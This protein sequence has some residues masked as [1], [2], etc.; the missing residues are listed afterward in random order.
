VLG[1]E[2]RSVTGRREVHVKVAAMTATTHNRFDE[3][4][5][6]ELLEGKLHE[7]FLWEGAGN[8]PD[9]CRGTAPVPYPTETPGFD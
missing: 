3:S 2:T 6:G 7:Q 9:I 1:L 8:G 5:T 4:Q